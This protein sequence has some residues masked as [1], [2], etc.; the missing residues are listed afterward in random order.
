MT[1]PSSLRTH[2][3][4]GR[5]RPQ[6]HAD[7]LTVQ[8]DPTALRP[9]A[10]ALPTGSATSAVVSTGVGGGAWPTPW[11]NS[12]CQWPRPSFFQTVKK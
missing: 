7:R 4:V 11:S 12:T 3:L 2:D 9:D 10:S 6:Y 5:A 1:K 8:R